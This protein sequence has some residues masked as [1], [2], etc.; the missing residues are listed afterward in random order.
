MSID[1]ISTEFIGHIKK[2]L[3]DKLLCSNNL[4]PETHQE[5]SS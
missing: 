4:L 3:T 1:E 5:L 2:E